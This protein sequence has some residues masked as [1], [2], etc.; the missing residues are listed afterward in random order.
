MT[1][2]MSITLYLNCSNVFNFG[3]GVPTAVDQP[4]LKQISGHFFSQWHYQLE[5]IP[6]I[7]L[8][9][10]YYRALWQQSCDD[11]RTST[12]INVV[13][14]SCQITG[15]CRSTGMNAQTWDSEELKI[16]LN[17]FGIYFKECNR[18]KEWEK[19][20][21]KKE[22]LSETPAWVGSLTITALCTLHGVWKC[23]APPPIRIWRFFTPAISTNDH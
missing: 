9:D 6:A 22:F 20:S 4:L 8:T 15:C 10:Y 21:S 7:F 3:L 17:F 23:P 5:M 16:G 1:P 12:I 2:D 13:F 19:Y 18:M 11:D 14:F